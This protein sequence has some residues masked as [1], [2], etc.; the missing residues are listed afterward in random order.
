MKLFNWRLSA[1]ILLPTLLFGIAPQ[2]YST[3]KIGQDDYVIN[4]YP[5]CDKDNTGIVADFSKPYKKCHITLIA[6]VS[7]HKFL[8][9]NDRPE[10]VFNVNVE[11]FPSNDGLSGKGEIIWPS[12][13]RFE[14]QIKAGLPF[15]K[16]KVFFPS[17]WPVESFTGDFSNTASKA[18]ATDTYRPGQYDSVFPGLLNDFSSKKPDGSR[19]EFSLFLMEWSTNLINGDGIL[20]YRDGKKIAGFFENGVPIPKKNNQNSNLA[21]ERQRLEDEQRRLTQQALADQ[22]R[23]EEKKRKLEDEDL[24]RKR[25]AA[26]ERQ[27]LEEEKS[28]LELARAQVETQRNRSTAAPDN[29]RRVALVIGN[30]R[31]TNSPL[32]NP[33]NDAEVISKALSASGF[34]VSRHD[35][36][37]YKKMRDVVRLF[38]EGIDK[39]DVAL[40]YFAGHAIQYQG[41]N[42][43]LPVDEDL[44]HE[45]E[46]PASALD[47]DFVLAK[48]ENAKND[49]NIVVL[50]ACRNNPL[51]SASRSIDRGLTT[52]NAAKGS[53]IAF[54]TSPNKVALD[55]SGNNSPYTKHLAE[56]I[57]RGGLTLEQ[58]FKEVRNNVIRETNNQQVPWEN[59]S[60]LGEFY[61]K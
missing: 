55:G 35:N 16:G 60:I 31:Y 46:I 10:V 52:V 53:F 18:Y 34:N 43:L 11:V 7:G 41:K 49:L 48:M 39:G 24:D 19:E 28:Q 29:R 25:Q 58:V 61:F 26:Q 4:K 23:L 30:A 21:E 12:G 36:L 13:V 45:N 59:S 9:E 44:K 56:A 22:Q 2:V 38:G 20:V 47:I 14:G 33:I 40:F 32:K 3:E 5:K 1:A 8:K 54:A 50:D 27:R 42:Y 17:E 51:G 57:R 6:D 15:G 37:N